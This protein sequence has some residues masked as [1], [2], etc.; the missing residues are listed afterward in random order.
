M[1]DVAAGSGRTG[2]DD[3]WRRSQPLGPG[4]L[5]QWH[6]VHDLGEVADALDRPV[7]PVLRGTDR[8]LSGTASTGCDRCRS[9]TTLRSPS[10]VPAAGTVG[11]PGPV[12]PGR[13]PAQPSPFEERIADDHAWSAA[14]VASDPWETAD[15]VCDRG[16]LRS[17][18]CRGGSY[19]V[20]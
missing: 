10:P 14:S 20:Q 1:I 4:S 16:E 5:C 15:R 12:L 8:H 2:R 7:R 11:S 17:A 9:A 3:Y 13:I 19:P 6:R 18:P